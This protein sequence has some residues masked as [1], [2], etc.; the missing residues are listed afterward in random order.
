MRVFGNDVKDYSVRALRSAF[1]VLPQS[2]TIFHGTVWDNI[3]LAC[4]NATDEEILRANDMA[5]MN[6]FKDCLKNGWDTV[7]G[8]GAGELTGGQ[9]VEEGI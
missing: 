8:D 9:I 5:Q 6:E 7:V 3:K 4:P 1:G 2:T